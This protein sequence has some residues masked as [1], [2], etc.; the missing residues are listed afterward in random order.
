MPVS[1]QSD[2]DSFANRLIHSAVPVEVDGGR[3]LEWTSQSGAQLIWQ[4]ES[5]GRLIDVN[6]HYAGS[7]RLRLGLTGITVGNLGSP[8]DGQ[9]E[10]SLAPETDDP[11]SGL[12][13]VVFDC[14]DVLALGEVPLPAIVDVQ[15]AAFAHEVE[16][17]PSVED[18][19]RKY[20]DGIRYASQSF[21]H[22]GL[23]GPDGP[24]ATPE[25]YAMLTGHVTATDRKSNELTGSAFIWAELESLPGSFDVVIDPELLAE[26]EPPQV[27]G[28]LDGLFWL[29]GRIP[30]L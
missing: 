20:T 27:G 3:Y 2:L 4:Q 25:A 26:T 23:I 16:T 24:P 1:D 11:E 28:V 9:I 21:V 13:P 10:G 15:V 6:P 7:S 18:Y 17:W 22:I 5:S 8:M 14:P 30:S 29:S 12:F 19:R